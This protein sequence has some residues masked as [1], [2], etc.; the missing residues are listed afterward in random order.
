MSAV[1]NS[2]EALGLAGELVFS[3]VDNARGLYRVTSVT[4][5]HLLICMQMIRSIRD[6]GTR[7]VDVNERF[8]PHARIPNV[9]A[10]A[11]PVGSVQL[12]RKLSGCTLPPRVA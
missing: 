3:P 7:S 12:G 8:L 5:I 6:T 9:K 2:L 1:I 11:L 4:G 10:G